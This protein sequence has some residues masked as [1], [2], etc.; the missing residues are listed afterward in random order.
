MSL[1]ELLS[2]EDKEKIVHYINR[3][4]GGRTN[5]GLL[6]DVLRTWNCDKAIWEDIFGHQ[7]IL[8]KRISYNQASDEIA[9]KM[10]AAWYYDDASAYNR[11]K[12]KIDCM[13]GEDT[14]QNNSYW[15]WRDTMR[16]F[17]ASGALAENIYHGDTFTFSYKNT[18]FV[19]S[20]GCKTLKAL[21]KIAEALGL[22]Q[23]FEEFRLAHSLMLNQKTI[24]GDL[25][26]SIHPLDYMTMSD[27]DCDWD[28]CM[29]WRNEG[30][31]RAGTVE[32]MNSSVA[33]V[34]YIRAKDDMD[35]REGYTWNNK[36]WRSLYVVDD[37]LITGVKGYPYQNASIDNIV[38][39]WIKELMAP[40]RKYSDI[41]TIT[42]TEACGQRFDFHG[43]EISIDFYTN[44][45][46]N[47]FESCSHQIA[48]SEEFLDSSSHCY[49]NCNY[50]GEVTCVC[51]G[52]IKDN[53]DEE[54]LRCS[55][56]GGTCDTEYCCECD[57][58]MDREDAWWGPDGDGP[59][60][61]NCYYEIYYDDCIDY[62]V[63]EN[64]NSTTVYLLS[65]DNGL[66]VEKLYEARHKLRSIQAL[67]DPSGYGKYYWE[68]KFVV[69]NYRTIEGAYY[70]LIE[71][72][73][74]QGRDCFGLCW[75]REYAQYIEILQEL[76]L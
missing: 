67:E 44:Q 63:H 40:V 50:S 6:N 60:C 46:Y 51:C 73:A 48:F 4:S 32:M 1:F 25:C 26:L 31:Y 54:C 11:F 3:Y 35:L 24:S 37:T 49:H 52:D 33:I 66:T 22:F 47:D 29:S 76:G 43:Q 71:D 18:S 62:S 9:N 72:L 56:C 14:S 59:Y 55:D 20:N 42:A 57:A 64:E 15:V 58:E 34:A 7:L 70:V 74:E 75:N 17:S 19:I 41:R 28:S 27:N 10:R 8:T 61:E 69:P 23:L 53:R 30:C 13:L 12:S 65:N 68:N 16:L 2:T 39:E 45:M 36:K 38:I 21:G 5:L